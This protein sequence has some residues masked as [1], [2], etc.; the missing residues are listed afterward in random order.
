M[1]D[2]KADL[3]VLEE[4]VQMEVSEKYFDLS[5]RYKWEYTN[6]GKLATAYRCPFDRAICVASTQFC[7]FSLVSV[8]C[9]TI[10]VLWDC[11]LHERKS[12]K[13]AEQAKEDKMSI[14]NYDLNSIRISFQLNI[15][16]CLDQSLCR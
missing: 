7:V 15:C 16:H 9:L 3:E 5:T 8:P 11:Y 4:A 2:Q 10:M 13:V 12:D 14:L 1:D 6:G